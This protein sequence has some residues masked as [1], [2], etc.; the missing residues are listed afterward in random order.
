M[1]LLAKQLKAYLWVSMTFDI[2]LF[3]FLALHYVNW[4][5]NKAAFLIFISYLSHYRILVKW[6][7]FPIWMLI[8]TFDFVM[9]ILVYKHFGEHMGL[10]L[11]GKF[12]MLICGF[13]QLTIFIILENSNSEDYDEVILTSGVICALITVI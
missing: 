6:I 1:V 3:T 10:N 5:D 2:L 11:M 13:T 12:G 9:G 4:K 8:I 7:L